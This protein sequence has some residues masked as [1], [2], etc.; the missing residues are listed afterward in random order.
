MDLCKRNITFIIK[1]N[2]LNVFVIQNN[3]PYMYFA[4][5]VLLK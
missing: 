1:K 2:K 3:I 5:V 4:R